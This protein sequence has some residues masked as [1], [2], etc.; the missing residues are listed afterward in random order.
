MFLRHW[1]KLI[2]RVCE[3]IHVAVVAAA[4]VRSQLVLPLAC[5]PVALQS[6]GQRR[7]RRA[8]AIGEI[9]W[10]GALVVSAAAALALIN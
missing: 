6:R 1:M 10:R 4:V 9:N 2:N 5:F 3:L 7:P 8:N